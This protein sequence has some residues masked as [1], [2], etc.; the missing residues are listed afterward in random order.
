MRI[1]KTNQTRQPLIDSMFPGFKGHL[2]VLHDVEDESI[3]DYLAASIDAIGIYMGNEIFPTDFKVLYTYKYDYAYPSNLLGWYCGRWNV[4]TMQILDEADV[5]VSAEYE[6]DFEHG[7]VYNHPVGRKITFSVGYTDKADVPPNLK[8]I[9]YRLAADFYENREANRVGDPKAL[10][11]WLE[12]SM[13][14]IW[15]PRV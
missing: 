2:R 5:D 15:Q 8:N 9:I 6:F 7:M 4:Q 1:V 10:P 14:S 11:N 12:Y 13:A 3:K